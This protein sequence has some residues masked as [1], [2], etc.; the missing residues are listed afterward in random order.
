MSPSP[1][2]PVRGFGSRMPT[3]SSAMSSPSC[4]RSLFRVLLVTMRWSSSS[5]RPKWLAH[6]SF[7]RASCSACWSRV[8][9]PRSGQQRPRKQPSAFVIKAFFTKPKFLCLETGFSPTSVCSPIPVTSGFTAVGECLVPALTTWT[10]AAWAN[11]IRAPC[12]HAEHFALGCGL[13]H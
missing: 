3:W 1:L 4:A 8:E 10:N 2:R 6:A 5:G 11:P 13:C 9:T 12:P 7:A